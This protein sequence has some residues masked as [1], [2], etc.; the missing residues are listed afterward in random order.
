MFITISFS[1]YSKD[2]E[3]SDNDSYP[4]KKQQY[5]CGK[6]RNFNQFPGAETV[7]FHKISTTAN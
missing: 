3:L 1:A 2:S 5:L 6:Y 4:T 7:S